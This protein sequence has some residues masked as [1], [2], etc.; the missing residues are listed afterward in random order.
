MIWVSVM[1]FLNSIFPCGSQ[2]SC[3][4]LCSFILPSSKS[5][6]FPAEM[7]VESNCPVTVPGNVMK[8]KFLV[9]LG[10]IRIPDRF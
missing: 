9:V 1:A 3:A 2:T 6:L 8:E 10:G 4:S 7:P 5:C